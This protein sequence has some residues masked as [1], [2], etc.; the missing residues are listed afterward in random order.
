MFH[1]VTI[2]PSEGEHRDL[3]PS[4]P[5]SGCRAFVL[6][7]RVTAVCVDRRDVR[8][9]VDS[10][11]VVRPLL[12]RHR[13]LHTERDPRHHITENANRLGD[14]RAAWARASTQRR[15]HSRQ[16][17]VC[18]GFA[19]THSPDGRAQRPVGLLPG[20]SGN[21]AA[22]RLQLQATA[23]QQPRGLELARLVIRVAADE[24]CRG[25]RVADI[26]RLRPTARCA[27]A[28]GTDS[29]RPTTSGS[30]GRPCSSTHPP[31]RRSVPCRSSPGACSEVSRT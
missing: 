19:N 27:A 30:S 6:V 21:S 12:V 4:V 28:T 26:A 8:A 25:R 29:S 7:H 3:R 18:A 2:K 17:D 14:Q 31:T 16:D 11:G 5:R 1:G 22:G 23:E 20:E 24:G 15:G 9:L 10:A 13:R